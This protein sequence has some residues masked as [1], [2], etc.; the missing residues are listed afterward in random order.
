MKYKYLKKNNPNVS[1]NV[2][3][4]VKMY[5]RKQETS[6]YDVLLLKVDDEKQILFDLILLDDN[7]KFHYIFISNFS[8]LSR[9]QITLHEHKIFICKRCFIRFDDRP[10][11]TKLNG[12]ETLT[13]HK[14]ICV[15]HKPIL[16]VLPVKGSRGKTEIHLVVI[17]S[18]FKALLS[19]CS[20]IK[21]IKNKI[22]KNIN[23]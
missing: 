1:V 8:R 14:L 18:D 16:P 13:K 9:S 11:K 5:K 15:L 6:I 23:Q 17:Y 2:Y 7:D 20:E 21:K 3:E 12:Q 4:L 10:K 22:I 19:E